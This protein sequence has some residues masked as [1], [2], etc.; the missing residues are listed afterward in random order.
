MNRSF[1]SALGRRPSSQKTCVA[2]FR[3]PP[4]SL[5]GK[6][7][8]VQIGTAPSN[9]IVTP[10]YVPSS[11]ATRIGRVPKLVG[12]DGD[13]F[14]HPL[15]QQNTGL[16]R[17]LPGLESMARS[18]LGGPSVEQA[19]YLENIGAA[20]R[21]GESQLPSVYKLLLEACEV[22][23][24]EAPGLYVRQ[25]AFP[26]A[27]TLA[28]AG[29]KPFIM[30]NTGLL[31]LLT[32][33]ELQGVIAHELGHLKCNHGVWLTIGNVLANGTSNLLP[34]I[35]SV[36]EESLFRWMR[37]AELTCDRSALLVVQDP[38]VVVSSLMKL[39][40]GA[41]N[42]AHELNVDAFLDQARSYDEATAGPLGTFLKTSQNRYLSHPLPVLRAREV[43][44][45][46]NS[47]QYK[48]LLA[49]HKR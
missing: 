35:S 6:V 36:A 44:R 43:D 18:V 21:V 15:D 14:R 25:N 11:S 45:W 12:L 47:A 29:K 46:A 38:R 4:K 1:Q 20:V 24:M 5:P 30:L 8:M 9:G 19:L 3:N 49:K 16:L 34:L 40:G 42:L 31:E 22:L 48:A 13:D 39:A 37:A 26:N 33:E 17:A 41:R 32:P 7:H 2:W 28:I 27:Y 10:A 23:S